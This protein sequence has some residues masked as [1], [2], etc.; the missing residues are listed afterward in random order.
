MNLRTR[1]AGWILRGVHPRDPALIELLG[2]NLTSAGVAVTAESAMRIA[3]NYSAMRVIS[4]TLA[5]LPLILYRRLP[6]GGK[7]R[8]T[9]HWLYP[10]LHTGPNAWMTSLAWR[11][12]GTLQM[13]LRG[14]CYSRIVGDPRGRRQMVPLNPDRI[15][16][17][18]R[19]NGQLAYDY[20][21]QQGGLVTLLQD[22]VLRIPFTTLDGVNPINPIQMNRETLGTALAAQDHHARFWA[23]DA[24]PTGGWIETEADFKDDQQRDKYREQ[25][26]RYMTGEN[27]HKTA[28]L[29]KGMKYHPLSMSTADVQYIESQKLSRSQIAGLWR[30][31]PH[32]IGDLERATFSN[33]EQQSIDFVV[34]TMQPWLRR[35]EQEIPRSLLSDREQETYFCEFLV[36]G[37]L[38]GDATARANYFRTAILTGWMSRNEVRVIE[39]MNRADNLDD[40]LVPLNMSPTDLLAEAVK[41][42]LK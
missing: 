29:K 10:L 18:L 14:A 33:V 40:Y 39:N 5:S 27:R 42:K 35:W 13:C 37:L 11:E 6:G 30:V 7:E 25:W 23:N 15:R 24:R 9:D 3:A 22:E 20:R 36:D 16:P 21:P 28:F 17:F 1:L 32:M 41:E 26:Q 8:A 19:D 31:P 34:F 12:M 38:R 2:G 4:E